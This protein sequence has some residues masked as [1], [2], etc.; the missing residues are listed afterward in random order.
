MGSKSPTLALYRA[1]TR[2]TAR[3]I[4]KA[5]TTVAESMLI[6]STT[7]AS[8]TRLDGDVLFHSELPQTN[9]G[10]SD[11]QLDRL[12]EAGRV[13]QDVTKHIGIYPQCACI[14]SMSYLGRVPAR[15]GGA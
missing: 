11:P 10:Y 15:A 8:S 5:M 4:A 14:V 2:L 13:E 9:G 12:P 3:W 7:T 1:H 6:L